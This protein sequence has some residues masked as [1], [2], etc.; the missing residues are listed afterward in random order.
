VVSYV[1]YWRVDYSTFLAARHD[2]SAKTLVRYFYAI[3][4]HPEALSRIREEVALRLVRARAAGEGFTV[5]DLDSIVY[6]LVEGGVLVY[7]FV[8]LLSLMKCRSR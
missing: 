8:R 2:T 3:A 6:T 1:A 7:L 5:A 4:K